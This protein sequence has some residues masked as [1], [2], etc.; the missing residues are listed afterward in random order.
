MSEN[1]AQ[2]TTPSQVATLSLAYTQDKPAIE[3][4]DGSAIPD[5]IPVVD[6]EGRV[7]AIYRAEAVPPPPVQSRSHTTADSAL[8]Y[9]QSYGVFDVGYA[10]AWTL[11]R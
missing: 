4:A 7:V 3:F 8:V 10:S 5:M 1:E 9:D 2:Q 11:G 6:G